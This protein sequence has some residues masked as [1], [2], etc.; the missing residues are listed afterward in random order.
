MN[1]NVRNHWSLLVCCGLILVHTAGC[2]RW[3]ELPGPSAV[4]QEQQS[5][6][7]ARDEQ[8]PLIVDRIR[9]SRNGS[10]QGVSPE[11]ESRILGTLQDIGLFASLAGTA[12]PASP[13]ADKVVRARLL[14]DETIDPH[15]GDAAWKGFV[16]GASMFTLAPFIPLDYEY[17]AHIALELER[18]DGQVRRYESQ[19]AGTMRYHLFGATPIMIDELKGHVTESCLD[20]LASQLVRDAEHYYASSAPVAEPG[21]RTVS[22]KPRSIPASASSPVVIPVSVPTEP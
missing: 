11:T 12:S 20:D 9:I 18:W 15:P 5:R 2:T 16:I 6:V 4:L 21:I 3:I 22:V 19:A 8:V 17:A 10:P 13:D 14:F 7:I 1:N